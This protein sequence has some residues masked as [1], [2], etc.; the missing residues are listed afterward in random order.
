MSQL[1]TE[2][3]LGSSDREWIH[4]RNGKTKLDLKLL[5]GLHFARAAS[6][7]QREEVNEVNE[8]S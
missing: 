3:Q 4:E 2:N 6:K 5:G 1:A 7:G 8:A